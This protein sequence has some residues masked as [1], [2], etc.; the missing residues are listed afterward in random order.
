MR[1]KVGDFRHR[2][3]A[4]GCPLFGTTKREKTQQDTPSLGEGGQIPAPNDN[5]GARQAVEVERGS[6]LG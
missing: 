4:Q 3:S 1:P 6:R 5:L 2:Q